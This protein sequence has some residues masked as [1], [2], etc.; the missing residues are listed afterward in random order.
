MSAEAGHVDAMSRLGH[1]LSGR[2]DYAGAEHWY[3]KAAASGDLMAM[4]SLGV[5]Q[6]Q[7]GDFAKAE[8]R[9]RKAAE[10]GLDYA[11]NNLGNLLL[12]RPEH[13]HEAAHWYRK[14]AE[15]GHRD[16]MNNLGVVLSWSGELDDA[17]RWFRESGLPYALD[18]LRQLQI[19]REGSRD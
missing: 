5:M 8:A 4:N 11:M 15:A 14:A 18:N 17:E 12:D 13:Q 10:A 16:A 1:R 9:F 7:R 6:Q 19:R 3:R 2:G